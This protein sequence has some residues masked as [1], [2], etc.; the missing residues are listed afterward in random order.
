M[1]IQAVFWRWVMRWVMNFSA[2]DTSLDK[3]RKAAGAGGSLFHSRHGTQISTV[4]VGEASAYWFIPKDKDSRSNDSNRSERLKP[5]LQKGSQ[6]PRSNDFSRC[7]LF[8][9]GGGWVYGWMP[10][11]NRLMDKLGRAAQASV[12]AVD[13]R[14]APEHPFPAALD[15]CLAAYRYLL[16]QKIDPRK[17]VIMGDSA[18]GNLA[19]A[20]MLSLK[21][22]GLP[23]PGAAVCLSPATD[24]AEQG[25]SFRANAAKEIVLPPSFV[26]FAKRSYAAG[27]DLRD[28]LISPLYGDLSGLPPLLVFVGGDEVLLSDGQQLVEKA[29]AA[30]V[31]ATLRVYPGMWHVWQLTPGLPEAER[32]IGEAVQ[33]IRE[34]T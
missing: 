18:G 14:L 3:K 27:H 17:I 32:A 30:G 2:S 13:Y 23:L 9:H 33:F 11:Y 7:I 26:A 25:D 22:A 28:P 24:L 8:L 31:D 16:E 10:L 5:P 15:D 19:L 34:K 6:D 12:L 4:R 1:S 21:S 29:V 20:C